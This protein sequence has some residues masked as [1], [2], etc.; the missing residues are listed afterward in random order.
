MKQNRLSS[1]VLRVGL[2]S[3]LIYALKEFTGYE[4]ANEMAEMFFKV[5]FI[6]IIAIAEIN[7]PTDKERW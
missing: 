7:N 4:L 2:A 5:L 1:P 3:L 6:I